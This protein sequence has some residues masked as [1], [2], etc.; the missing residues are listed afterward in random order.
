MFMRNEMFEKRTVTDERLKYKGRIIYE[1]ILLGL[2][3]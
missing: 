2:F 3:K 1:G